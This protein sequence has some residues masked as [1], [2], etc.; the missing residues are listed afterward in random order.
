MTAAEL[1]KQMRDEL[2]DEML[3]LHGYILGFDEGPLSHLGLAFL[4]ASQHADDGDRLTELGTEFAL[5]R[6]R[7]FGGEDQLQDADGSAWW[8]WVYEA[9]M[10]VDVDVRA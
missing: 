7:L 3:G 10:A 6:L 9:V 2:G 4:Y 5:R 1:I 8:S